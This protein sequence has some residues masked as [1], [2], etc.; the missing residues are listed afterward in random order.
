MRVLLLSGGRRLTPEAITEVTSILGRTGVDL[1]ITVASGT[2]LDTRCRWP[3][4]S[5]WGHTRHSAGSPPSRLPL[6]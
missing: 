2:P 4:T 6:P 5:S 1:H 3:A